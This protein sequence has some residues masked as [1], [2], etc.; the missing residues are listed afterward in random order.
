[1]MVCISKDYKTKRR[2]IP[3]GKPTYDEHYD[4][5]MSFATNSDF[6]F[7]GKEFDVREPFSKESL[8]TL[9]DY[10][11]KEATLET[12]EPSFGLQN[13]LNIGFVLNQTNSASIV[14]IGFKFPKNAI[15]SVLYSGNNR[16]IHY[17]P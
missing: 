6:V 11:C 13:W 2:L 15:H 3:E 14:E 16:E 17:V 10:Y 8:E 1:M 5:V 7:K 4:D 9:L 12:I